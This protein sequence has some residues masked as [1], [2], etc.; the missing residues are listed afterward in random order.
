M[1]HVDVND[2]FFFWI[3]NVANTFA[4]YVDV[5]IWNSW[6]CQNRKL[7]FKCFNCLS[8]FVNYADDYCIY[9]KKIKVFKVKI[10]EKL[11]RSMSQKKSWTV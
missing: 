10:I 8:Y 7:I 1:S 4:K 3:E 9:I 5:S 6:V 2:F 11:L